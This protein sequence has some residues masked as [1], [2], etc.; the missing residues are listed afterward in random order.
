[1][2]APLLV[3]NILLHSMPVATATPFPASFHAGCHGNPIPSHSMPVATA[4]V[5]WNLPACRPVGANT[6]GHRPFRAI[7]CRPF[8]AIACRPFRAIACRPFRALACRP[9]RAIACRPFRA[10]AC[11]PFRAIACRPF[12]A[13]ACRPFRAIACRSLPPRERSTSRNER[14]LSTHINQQYASRPLRPLCEP[15]CISQ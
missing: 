9:F 7:A 13:I 11:R 2:D 10:I 8:R 4:T 12:R 14:H 1:M 3:M 5:A 6:L 15:K